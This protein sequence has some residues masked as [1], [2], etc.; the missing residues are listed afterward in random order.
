MLVRGGG[1]W[2]G[3]EAY[4]SACGPGVTAESLWPRPRRRHCR[5][6]ASSASRCARGDARVRACRHGPTPSA[7][8]SCCARFRKHSDITYR[9]FDYD[10]PRRGR[11]KPAPAFTSA[12]RLEVMR[13]G[14]QAGGAL[15]A[16]APSP[17]VPSRK[18]F[19]V[20]CRH[21]ATERWEFPRAQS[22][23]VTSPETF[24]RVDFCFPAKGRIGFAGGAEALRA[25]RRFGCCQ[26]RSARIKSKPEFP[27]HPAAERTSPDLQDFVRRLADEARRR[28]RRGPRVGAPMEPAAPCPRTP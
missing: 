26:R 23:R 13:F 1:A 9:V 8:A 25:W 22:P 5:K 2:K 20:A 27:D 4:S 16:G 7:P 12:R 14:D 18:R 11:Q 28:K 21:F 6:T 15:P 17:T 10:R 19:Y 3:A 24:R